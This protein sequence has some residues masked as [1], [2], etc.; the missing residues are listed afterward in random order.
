MALVRYEP[1]HVVNRLHHTLDQ[2]FNNHFGDDGAYAGLRRFLQSESEGR[3]GKLKNPQT[4][5]ATLIEQRK[6]HEHLT[7]PTD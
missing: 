5:N 3:Q 2:V 4:A 1:W 6:T 7:K